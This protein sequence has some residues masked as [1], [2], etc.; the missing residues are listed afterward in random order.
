VE[1]QN[2]MPLIAAICLSQTLSFFGGVGGRGNDFHDPEIAHLLFTTAQL[3]G[4][5]ILLE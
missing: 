4:E 3:C 2:M 5:F 1:A